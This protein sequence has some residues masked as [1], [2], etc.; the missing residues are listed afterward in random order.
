M[1]II[2]IIIILPY[3]SLNPVKRIELRAGG[4]VALTT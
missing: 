2:I 3:L 4:S 1:A